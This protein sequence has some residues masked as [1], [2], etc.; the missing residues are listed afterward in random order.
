MPICSHD[1]AR[2]MK[3]E[4]S[5]LRKRILFSLFLLVIYG[6]GKNIPLPYTDPT[7]TVQQLQQNSFW[8]LTSVATGGNFTAPTLFSLGLAPWM[9]GI[10]F[11]QLLTMTKIFG[12]DQLPQ[13]QVDLRRNLFILVVA[14]IEGVGTVL[15]MKGRFIDFSQGQL[16]ELTLLLVAGSFFLIWLANINSVWGLGGPSL[17]ILYG[18][19]G[20]L[21]SQFGMIIRNILTYPVWWALGASMILIVATLG[22]IALAFIFELSEYRLEINRIMLNQQLLKTSYVPLKLNAGGSM[23]FM[24]GLTMLM[25]PQALFQLLV[26]YFPGNKILLW[27]VSNSSSTEFFGVTVY[28]IV[29]FSLTMLFAYAMLDMTEMADNLRKS[30][31]Y[32]TGIDPGRPTA[33]YLRSKQRA[34]AFI[35]ATFT[36]TVAGLPLY[37]GVIWPKYAAVVMLPGMSIMLVGLAVTVMFQV[38]AIKI[39]HN[40]DELF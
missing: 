3:K 18:I 21:G 22:V 16:L 37:L 31:D 11:W 39:L 27:L 1:I 33:K 24:F 8:Q 2:S 12:L 17:L 6:F 13:K 38:R 32:F 25:L 36:V 10:I 29:L 5:P 28:N 7:E 35:G 15:L 4:K 19:V 26:E 34:T 40:Y 30:G 20:S 9:A 14:L 23:A